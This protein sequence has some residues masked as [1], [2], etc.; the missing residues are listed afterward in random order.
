MNRTERLYAIAE[1]LRRTGTGGVTAASLASY[2]E[3]STRT[4]K[5]DITALQQSGLPVWAQTGA[6]GGYFLADSATLPP[7]NFTASQAVAVS[8][9]LAVMPAGSPFNADGEAAARKIRDALGPRASE[10]AAGVASRVWVRPP[11]NET[12]PATSTVL[13]AIEQSL[14]E[15]RTLVIS[16]VNAGKEA[17]R[18]TVEPTILA[19]ANR[20]WYLVGWCQERNDTRWFRLDRIR[21]ASLTKTNYTPRPVADIGEPPAA[22]RPVDEPSLAVT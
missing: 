15:H 16:Y 17:S 13:R 9:A 20:R 7:V 1:Q 14:I 2:L 3:V 22:A 10:D 4:I 18:R 11:Q 21:R 19:W 8:V 6:G 5:R 12:P